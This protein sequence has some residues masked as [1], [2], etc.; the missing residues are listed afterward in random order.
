MIQ[1][2]LEQGCTPISISRELQRNGW[3]NPAMQEAL[4]DI[5]L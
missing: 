5:P 2:S 4:H 1:L 3:R